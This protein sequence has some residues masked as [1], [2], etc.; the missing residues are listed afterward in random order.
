MHLLATVC[1]ES[2]YGTCMAA[3]HGG[4]SG[5]EDAVGHGDDII[6]RTVKLHDEVVAESV[7]H[8]AAV[9]CGIA[10]H[11]ASVGRYAYCRAAVKGIDYHVGTVRFGEC[12]AEHGCAFR[13]SNLGYDI[14]VGEVHLIIIRCGFLPLVGEPAGA[15]LFIEDGC[16]RGGHQRKLSV[17]IDPR[18]W[19]MGLLYTA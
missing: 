7:G 12:E 3:L 13:G 17:V 5:G 11:A 9:A 8:S 6:G 2:G 1:A 16:A 15:L 14:M 19:L 10:C 4:G 18:A